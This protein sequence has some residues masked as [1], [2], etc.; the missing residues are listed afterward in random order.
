MVK[1]L[2]FVIIFEDELILWLCNIDSIFSV[3]YFSGYRVFNYRGIKF[4]K[5]MVFYYFFYFF[6]FDGDVLFFLNDRLNFC[7]GKEFL[8]C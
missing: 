5:G 1:V 6:V 8:G 2:Y 3:R 7:L 4:V